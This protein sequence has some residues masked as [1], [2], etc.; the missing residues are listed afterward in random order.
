MS[1]MKNPQVQQ[2]LKL[3]QRECKKCNVRVVLST[4]Y[5]VNCGGSRVQG[6]FQSPDHKNNERGTL[7]VGTGNRS[8]REWL[9][10]LVHEYAHFVQW[11]DEDPVFNEKDYFNL[12]EATEKQA[13]AL[14]RQYKLPIQRAFLLKE[15]RKYMKRLAK[16]G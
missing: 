3:V 11:R 1:H 14:C 8:T 12:E 16:E 5:R 6:Y 10:T 9:F 15:H 7:I 13:I 4:G 2:F